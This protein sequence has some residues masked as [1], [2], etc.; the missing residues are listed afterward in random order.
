M[1]EGALNDTDA[2]RA[3]NSFA[4][5]ALN[6]QQVDPRWALTTDADSSRTLPTQQRRIVADANATNQCATG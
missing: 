2:A 6:G 5:R 3:H 1:V 4:G